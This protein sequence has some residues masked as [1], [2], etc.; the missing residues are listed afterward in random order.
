MLELTNHNTTSS[1][2]LR[3][4][5]LLLVYSNYASQEFRTLPIPA[6]GHYFKNCLISKKSQKSHVLES[7]GFE[8][9][10][11]TLCDEAGLDP[12]KKPE[13]SLL[14]ILSDRSPPKLNS[15]RRSLDGNTTI[16]NSEELEHRI[17]D[18]ESQLDKLAERNAN[19]KAELET[20][21]DEL[22]SANAEIERFSQSLVQNILDVPSLTLPIATSPTPPSSEVSSVE[23]TESEPPE[24]MIS[25]NVWKMISENRQQIDT[26][27]G[28]LVAS[29]LNELLVTIEK[30]IEPLL[31]RVYSE[32]YR[33]ATAN[34]YFFLAAAC[35]R[36]I[37]VAH[38]LGVPTSASNLWLT[39]NFLPK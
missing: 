30:T 36:T 14:T 17:F 10:A 16:V 23:Q 37:A 13:T 4:Q 25:T 32:D 5:V 31:R 38:L 21:I 15:P 24:K 3:I 33:R 27:Q 1:V 35:R 11:S 9:S 28:N 12:S 39:A 2:N 22:Q 20:K 29:N 19:L 6:H 18:L 34:Q 26:Q 7:R 8:Y